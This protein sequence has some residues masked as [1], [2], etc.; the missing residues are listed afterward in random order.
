MWRTDSL[1]KDNV[2]C[3]ELTL[4]LMSFVMKLY[5]NKLCVFVSRPSRQTY[6]IQGL[7]SGTWSA[8][9]FTCAR[10]G[11]YSGIILVFSAWKCPAALKRSSLGVSIMSTQYEQG[12]WLGWTLST[13]KCNCSSWFN[14]SLQQTEVSHL[15]STM[16]VELL[17]TVPAN[18]SY[19]TVALLTHFSSLHV[20]LCFNFFLSFID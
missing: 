18:M 8:T 20:K 16:W 2:C 12:L 3:N 14:V 5:Y 4:I 6:K 17:P 7:P 10:S 13:W 11:T 19:S 15:Y 9:L 1:I